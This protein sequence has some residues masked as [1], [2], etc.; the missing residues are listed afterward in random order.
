MYIKRDGKEEH[1]DVHY[2]WHVYFSNGEYLGTLLLWGEPKHLG[3]NFRYSNRGFATQAVRMFTKMYQ[4]HN[5]FGF[6][7]LTCHIHEKHI[8]SRRV[9]EKNN[10]TLVEIEE[11]KH[12]GYERYCTYQY[13]T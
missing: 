2:C 12:K 13:L 11:E 4:D 10:F 1:W 9:V 8:A 3:Y 6:G 7:P 5:N